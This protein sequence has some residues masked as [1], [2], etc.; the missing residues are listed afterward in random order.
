MSYTDYMDTRSLIK[1]EID[2]VKVVTRDS[3]QVI[4][5]MW[6]SKYNSVVSE[7]ESAQSDIELRDREIAALK[8]KISDMS[9]LC[10]TCG[11]ADKMMADSIRQ[12][13]VHIINEWC[14]SSDHVQALADDQDLYISSQ[15]IDEYADK[16]EAGEA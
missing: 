1:H 15:A 4:F 11:E 8:S 13:K 12:A 5:E 3:A 2:D 6:R 14:N 10:L 9:E 7:L 16:V